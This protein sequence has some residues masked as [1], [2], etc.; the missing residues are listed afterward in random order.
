MKKKIVKDLLN[1]FNFSM[2]HFQTLNSTMDKAMEVLKN[3]KK[4]CVI[5]ADEQKKG[6]GRRGNKWISP[7]GNI[8]LTISIKNDFHLNDYFNFSMLTLVS[9]KKA[10]EKFNIKKIN[11]KWPN[12]IFYNNHKIGGILIESSSF[13]NNVNFAIIGVGIN[14]MNSPKESKYK[15]TH[16]NK[17]IQLD[18]KYLFI[19]KFLKYFLIYWDNFN[20][21]KN[22]IKKIFEDSIMFLNKKIKIFINDNQIVKGVFIGINHDGSLRLK[23][24][25]NLINIYSGSIII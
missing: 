4:N 1:N 14:F 12:D 16:V 20:N 10:F 24:K 8:Y 9:L 18:N 5:L 17:I 2:Y 11:F 15:T 22:S 6:R 3:S 13:T 7:K 21:E 23:T 19:E 25:D